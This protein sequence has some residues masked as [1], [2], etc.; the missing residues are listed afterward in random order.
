MPEVVGEDVVEVEGSEE[1][2]TRRKLSRQGSR[3]LVLY[4]C[5]HRAENCSRALV[6]NNKWSDNTYKQ[7]TV[8]LHTKQPAQ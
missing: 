6:D 7:Q 3:S 5:W 4:V 8:H 2:F 1:S